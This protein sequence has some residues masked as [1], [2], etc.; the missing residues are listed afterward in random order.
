MV[1]ESGHPYI[2]DNNITNC[3]TGIHIGSSYAVKVVNNILEKNSNYGVFIGFSKPYGLTQEVINNIFIDNGLTIHE[4]NFDEFIV[5]NNYVNGLPLGYFINQQDLIIT[6]KYG[7]IFLI[8][9][10]NITLK[11]Q[12]C[13]NTE[14][15]ILIMESSD[16]HLINCLVSNCPSTG[17]YG[18]L[19][20]IDSNGINVTQSTF[21]NNKY[22]IKV[23]S[24]DFI[25]ISNNTF[26]KNS[27]AI[28]FASISYCTLTWNEFISNSYAF[29]ISDEIPE[30]IIHHNYFYK[31][32]VLD[33]IG[34]N[35]M[36]YDVQSNEGNWW[37]D[38]DGIGVYHI[39][40]IGSSVAMDPFPLGAKV[41]IYNPNSSFVLKDHL[42]LNY[43]VVDSIPITIYIDGLA[44]RSNIPDGT[45]ISE[46]KDGEHNFTF[47]GSDNFNHIVEITKIFIVDTIPPII[48]ISN[49]LNITFNKDYI[50][51]EYNVSGARDI[52][53]Y[54]DGS[55][56]KKYTPIPDYDRRSYFSEKET[57]RALHNGIHNITVIVQDV[58]GNIA[59]NTVL[60][61]INVTRTTTSQET[62]E[63]AD[64][65]SSSPPENNVSQFFSINIVVLMIISLVMLKKKR[66]RV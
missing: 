21:R 40:G 20:I 48:T 61:S 22:G 35:N 12:N 29:K 36:W 55:M 14:L 16:C 25:H 7:Q 4:C 58:A 37:F 27:E 19:R 26:S 5:L 63:V 54:L 13:S 50:M 18:G 43:T 59:K 9:C 56:K 53:I 64:T 28:C 2:Y 10:R 62:S 32:D 30:L 1:Y 49:P 45:L 3:G 46:L 51:L 24:S 15:A 39:R 23:V 31:S 47:I 52:Y 41:I 34:I 38:Y 17:L 11:N 6:I 65:Y 60:F 42:Y 44:N 57:F 66:K 33:T 8:N